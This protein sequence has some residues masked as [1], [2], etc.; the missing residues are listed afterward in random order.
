MRLGNLVRHLP[1]HGWV[2]DVVAGPVG[3][4]SDDSLAGGLA[5]DR[6]IRVAPS[7]RGPRVQGADW[8]LAAL[9][10]ALRLAREADLALVSGGPF[11]PFA[12][13]PL[14]GRR[15][16]LDFRDPWSWE[17]RFGRLE[18]RG[19]RRVGLALERRAEAVAVNRA[20]AIITVAPQITATYRRLYPRIEGRIATLRHGFEPSDFLAPQE[21]SLEE[22]VLV[23]AGSFLAGE[24][25]PALLVETAR[26][27]RASGTPLR[28]RLLGRLPAE[29]RPLITTAEQ[30]GWLT[31][32]GQVPHRL[33]LSALRSA[34]ALWLEPGEL[35]FLITGKVYECLASGRPLVAVAPAGGALAELLAET[36]GGIVT[37]ATP[38]ACAAAV[39]AALAGAAPER[40]E[41]AIAAL[42]AP[43][44]AGALASILD[45]AASR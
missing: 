38:E 21:R 37:A 4:E 44:L 14:L 20:S 26:L 36:G 34:S 41:D 31:S 11:A 29:L 23:Y 16:V 27:V 10:P 18:P 28:V 19:R 9:R 35:P 12:L 3:P 13:G 7:A 2:T 39:R 45:S 33:A 32:A 17:P 15:Y 42:A 8:A 43:V 5:L 30:E 25:T 40:R 1:E 22:P 6:V 24:R